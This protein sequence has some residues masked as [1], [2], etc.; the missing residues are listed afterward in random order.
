MTAEVVVINS[1]GIAMAADSA[2]TIGEQKIYNSAVKLFA[3]S[4]TEP[5]GIMIYGSADLS[6]TPWE[7][8]IKQYRKSLG[9]KVFDTLEE[10]AIN[11][12]D[13][14]KQAQYSSSEERD[15]GTVFQITIFIQFIVSEIK[16]SIQIQQI[17]TEGVIDDAQLQEISTRVINTLHQG[18]QDM[19]F[20]DGTGQEDFDK[21]A[22][23]T[24]S[25]FKSLIKK[26]F[27]E[28]LPKSPTTLNKLY[29]SVALFIIKP[30]QADQSSGIVIAGYGD[31]EIYPVVKSYEI[32]GYIGNA[33]RYYP[34]VNKSH[35]VN[36]DRSPRIIPFA[37][38]DMIELFMNGMS[39]HTQNFIN[40]YSAKMFSKIKDEGQRAS[41]D[42]EQKNA[43]TIA[44]DDIYKTMHNDIKDYVQ[45][46]HTSPVMQMVGVLP[47]DELA[48]MAETLINLT[49]FKRK[50]TY[51]IESVGGPVDVAIISKGDGLVWI[52]RKHYFP[53]EL[54]M[55][56][57]NNYYRGI[58]DEL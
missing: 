23:L 1:N 30:M 7:I 2:V 56:F 31:N 24:R 36:T 43:L 44:I 42:S 47:K 32:S 52:K 50:M 6:S 53:K 27:E 48:N 41:L 21:L 35:D 22:E 33:L 51:S 8:I 12:I 15:K 20:I 3:L 46:E 29:D 4:K 49:A 45:N 40:D 11:F 34:I 16:K 25:S 18:L 26:A 57:Y 10:Y 39:S 13:F 54:N 28:L 14:L 37:Q 5:V 19:P 38:S 58:D 9:C 55:S 17:E